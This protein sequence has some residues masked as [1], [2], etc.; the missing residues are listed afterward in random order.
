MRKIV[1]VI[2]IN[3]F[4]LASLYSQTKRNI[5][6]IPFENTGKSKF[7]WVGFGVEYLLST[8]LSNISAYYVPQKKI[9]INALKKRGALNSKKNSEVIYQVGRETGINVAIVGVYS[10]SGKKFNLTIKLLNAFSGAE[11]L[12]NSYSKNISN[13]FDTVDEIIKSLL[14]LTSVRLSSQEELIVNRRMTSSMKAFENFS[15][16]YIENEKSK[17][18]M[19]VVTSLFKRAIK[20]DPKFWEAYYNLG[21]AYFNNKK[22]NNALNQFSTIIEALPNF[23]K[24]YYGRGLIYL[25]KKEYKKA[26][27]DF[28]RVVEAN[29]NDYK[30]YFYLGKIDAALKNYRNAKKQFDKATSINP[31]DPDIYFEL[32]NIWFSRNKFQESIPPYKK[33]IQLDP[34]NYNAR[35]KLG[36]SYYRNQVYYSAINEFETIIESKPTDPIANFMLGIT[37]YKQAVLNDLIEAFLELLQPDSNKKK[38]KPASNKSIRDELYNKMVRCFDNAQ[39]AKPNFLEATFNL[40]LTY[41]ELEQYDNALNFYKKTLEI[42][43]ILIKAHIKLANTLESLGQKEKALQKYK[44]VIGIDPAYF[45]AHPTL[46]PI[47]QYINIIDV[48]L[49]ELADKLK[50]NPNDLKSNQTLAKIYYAQGYYGK[51]AN[52]YRKILTINPRHAEAKKMLAKLEKK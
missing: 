1:I 13:L 2:I 46:G 51:S 29:P 10:V 44:E 4:L 39:K 40:A 31:D 33:C 43:P 27:K 38:N 7:D 17:V 19:E 5:G 22:Y 32:G 41:Q 37:V 26:K 45:V 24:P 30:G 9:I 8:K 23:E 36:E 42:D 20:E 47:H 50:N 49:K 35:Q 34:E 28:K 14:N 6:I 12:S 52:L 3:A 25:E 15:L 18:K 11:I 48:T 21:I 16:A